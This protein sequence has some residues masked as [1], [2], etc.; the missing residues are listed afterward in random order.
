ML[1]ELRDAEGAEERRARNGGLGGRSLEIQITNGME[2]CLAGA[3][4][5]VISKIIM[6]PELM[7][8]LH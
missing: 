8:V 6:E 5:L 3:R 7:G 1:L 4:V 2:V